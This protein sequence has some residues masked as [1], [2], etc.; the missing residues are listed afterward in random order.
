MLAP[1]DLRTLLQSP[2]ESTTLDFKERIAWSDRAAKLE[3]ARDIVC[4]A[5]RNG[6]LLVVGVADR[7]GGRFDPVGLAA[8]QSIPDA[9][10]IAR[11]VA[12]HFD[13]PVIIR[14]SEMTVEGLRFGVIQVDEFYR[15][16]HICRVVGQDSRGHELFRPGDL[17]RR[18]DTLDCSRVD[19]A[20]GLQNLIESAASKT[21]AIVRSMLPTRGESAPTM[22]DV[23]HS[24]R[25]GDFSAPTRACDLWP[26]PPIA[27]VSPNDLPR[28]LS[29]ATVQSRAG[30]LIPR[31][32]DLAR[33]APSEFVR[34]P[35]RIFAE[36]TRGLHSDDGHPVSVVELNNALTVRLRERLWEPEGKVDFTSIVAYVLGCLLFGHRLFTAAGAGRFAIRVGLLS[37]TGLAMTADP[38]RY[39]PFRQSYV[40]TSTV[41]ILATR[42]L[43]TSAHAAARTEV[44]HNIIDE[45]AWYF[46]FAVAPDAFEAHLANTREYVPGV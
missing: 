25:R 4:L 38:A 44:A 21:G 41:D 13:P 3:L 26:V 9:T 29:A 11:L 22:T 42:E 30:T 28:L 27:S 2:A 16:P 40:A 18:S 1:G 36:T 8:D 23:D 15:T 35:E 10:E 33:L 45:L 43:D 14:A 37:P 7:G 39:V 5:N 20:D 31:A 6:G 24:W 12:K 46:G 34:E 19:T 17:L 32:I